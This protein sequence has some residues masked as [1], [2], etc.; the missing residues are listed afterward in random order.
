MREEEEEER[1]SER[2]KNPPVLK[3]KEMWSPIFHDFISQ[4]LM[5]DPAH[6]HTAAEMLL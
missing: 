6:R 3:D 1:R 2:E 4:C 5:K